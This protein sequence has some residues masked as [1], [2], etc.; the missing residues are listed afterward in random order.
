MELDGTVVAR[1]SEAPQVFQVTCVQ[2]TRA[3]ESE[4]SATGAVVA[5]AIVEAL[6]LLLTCDREGKLVL[7]RWPSAHRGAA[8]CP[9]APLVRLATSAVPKD[10][11][12]I[13]L[14]S[15][16]RQR[17]FL[18]AYALGGGSSGSAVHA[19]I[20]TAAGLA[21]VPLLPQVDRVTSACYNDTLQEVVLASANF[22]RV[23]SVRA[24]RTAAAK[25]KAGGAAAAVFGAGAGKVV[26]RTP[27]RIEISLA[28]LSP[29]GGKAAAVVTSLCVDGPRNL[30]CG[31]IK[32][33]VSG[34]HAVT[35]ALLFRTADFTSGRINTLAFEPV[36]CYLAASIAEESGAWRVDLWQLSGAAAPNARWEVLRKLTIPRKRRVVACTF[37]E[38]APKTPDDAL[39]A[40]DAHATLCCVDVDRVLELWS[41]GDDA[42]RCVCGYQLP[43]IATPSRPPT[44]ASAADGGSKS[45]PSKSKRKSKRKSDSGTA[46]TKITTPSFFFS[47]DRMRE[48][49]I[50]LLGAVGP[51]LYSLALH[52]VHA[53]HTRA[54]SEAGRLIEFVPCR[55]DGRRSGGAPAQVG[56]RKRSA[57]FT[58]V[59]VA[60]AVGPYIHTHMP[61]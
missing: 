10:A 56:R 48:Q 51:S 8:P 34:W 53:D 36:G 47:G 18:A 21:D 54:R 4:A 1:Q 32:R 19:L 5:A 55:G 38:P 28:S 50:S 41:V 11:A 42:A 13:A 61:V 31:V 20:P 23:Y 30:M 12:P 35:G 57:V 33:A 16:P 37:A 15:A 43:A 24:N 60:V 25:G 6:E 9:R 39:V 2:P 29:G 44:P 22:L 45:S 40:R 46:S 26:F 59:S 27:L 7:W 14:M 52:G 58:V 3:E 49:G 17:L